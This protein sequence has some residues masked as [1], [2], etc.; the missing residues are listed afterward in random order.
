MNANTMPGFTAERS[1]YSNRKHYQIGVSIVP[2][3]YNSQV[4]TPAAF[5]ITCYLNS[6]FR[7]YGRCRSIGYGE[8]ACAE[9]ADGVAGSVCR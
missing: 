5:N 4:V 8:D 2:N 1:L 6:Y 9:V 3:S 7:T